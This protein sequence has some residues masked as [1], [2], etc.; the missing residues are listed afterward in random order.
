MG[1]ASNHKKTSREAARIGREGLPALQPMTDDDPEDA[2]LAVLSRALDDVVPGVAGSVV[3]D[4]AAARR[5]A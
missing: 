2:E 1:R 3:G 4:T 5:A